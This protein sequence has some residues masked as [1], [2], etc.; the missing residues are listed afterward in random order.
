M[1][2]NSVQLH[3]SEFKEVENIM[4]KLAESNNVSDVSSVDINLSQASSMIRFNKTAVPQDLAED[5]SSH[6]VSGEQTAPA[7]FLVVQ[8]LAPLRTFVD[9]HRE[10]G[11]V[12]PEVFEKIEGAYGILRDSWEYLKEDTEGWGVESTPDSDVS[13]DQTTL[14]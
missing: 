6:S 5:I 7:K 2:T 8:V 3:D 10:S 13:E 1:K 4:K 11:M 12:T 9:N 14:I